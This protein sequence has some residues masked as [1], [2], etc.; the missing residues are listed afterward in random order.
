[1]KKLL[2]IFFGMLLMLQEAS[3]QFAYY[4]SA[5]PHYAVY[6]KTDVKTGDIRYEINREETAPW[7]SHFMP[8]RWETK[9]PYCIWEKRFSD[10][11]GIG[12]VEQEMYPEQNITEDDIYR[13]GGCERV[14]KHYRLFGY[15]GFR[16]V[17]ENRVAEADAVYATYPGKIPTPDWELL[18]AENLSRKDKN[19]N[20]IVTDH[21]I[22]TQFPLFHSAYL[23]GPDY[24]KG[25]ELVI[26]VA[27]EITN[28][29]DPRQF[30]RS[31]LQPAVTQRSVYWKLTHEKDAPYRQYEILC[32]DGI[33]L[34]GRVENGVKLPFIYRYNGNFGKTEESAPTFQS[35]EIFAFTYHWISP[36]P[37]NW[38]DYTITKEKFREDI[39]YLY[40]NGF[41]FA[42]A[43]ELYKMNGS[44]PSEKIALITFDDGYA[45]CY[46]EALPVLEQYG[47]K[48]TM[49]MV[50]SYIDTEDYLTKEQLRLLSQSPL[51]E[52]GN[53]SYALH[54][55][56][57]TD[58]LS[59]YQNDI[60]SALS[61]YYRNEEVITEIT[62]KTITSLS[63]PYG[64]YTNRL[65]KFLKEHG[66]EVT[67][68]TNAKNN[69]NTVLKAPLNRLNRSFYTPVD[70]LIQQF[71]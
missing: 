65:E 12:W 60:D 3:A 16:I 40:E 56:P 66:Y 7:Q 63:F 8:Y 70:V 51:I 19:G 23:S 10:L 9:I 21:M 39:R 58:V 28:G 5:Y 6:E 68:S 22:T 50:G 32:L 53:H 4:E 34:D 35:A 2:M 31:V 14:E 18:S 45:S 26:D 57:R 13:L 52:I 54:T 20:Y 67:F 62:G 38:G 15:G 59:Q 48:A 69:H 44:Y 42:T 33:T 41:Y 17:G 46:T 29:A 30:D 43:S 55:L 36:N 71:Q 27:R 37:Q 49:F 64:I 24:A 1:M 25:G 61:D 11:P 47:A